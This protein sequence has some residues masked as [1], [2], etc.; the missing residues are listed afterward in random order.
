[1]APSRRVVFAF[2]ATLAATIV[3]RSVVHRSVAVAG[4][5]PGL[6]DATAPPVRATPL[7]TP[8]QVPHVEPVGFDVVLSVDQQ[9]LDEDSM[10]I[11]QICPRFAITIASVVGKTSEGFFEEKKIGSGSPTWLAGG[12]PN[13]CAKR[14]TDIPGGTPLLIDVSF[15]GAGTALTI[16]PLFE[17]MPTTLTG[18]EPVQ[19]QT[20]DPF[21]EFGVHPRS[22]TLPHP[23]PRP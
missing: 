15:V 5:V 17:S 21:R 23:A 19:P 7:A 8:T 22:V 13:L 1:M 6:I 16:G 14:F 20:H 12:S 10:T 4:P 9:V 11:A 18:A 3:D 2:T